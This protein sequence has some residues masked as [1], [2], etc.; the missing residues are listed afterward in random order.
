MYLVII[1]T[2]GS[3]DNMHIEIDNF[4]LAE[5]LAEVKGQ[6]PQQVV[7]WGGITEYHYKNKNVIKWRNS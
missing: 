3:I 6:S 4:A 7:E 5:E 2:D 1:K